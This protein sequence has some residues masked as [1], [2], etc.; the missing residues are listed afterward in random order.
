MA[1]YRFVSEKAL[2][3]LVTRTLPEGTQRSAML[4]ALTRFWARQPERI[5]LVGATRAAEILGV[6]PTHISR[7]RESGQLPEPI[8]VEGAKVSVFV[9][10]DVEEL[11]AVMAAKRAKR[12]ASDD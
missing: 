6:Q 12:G 10:E 3:R 5:P 7:L 9:R 1:S 2:R 8:A 11:A 4:A